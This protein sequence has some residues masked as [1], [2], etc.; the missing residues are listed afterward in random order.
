M[1]CFWRRGLSNK[2]HSTAGSSWTTRYFNCCQWRYIRFSFTFPSL[3]PSSH[4]SFVLW[5]WLR[6]VK[7]IFY[8]LSDILEC[9][10]HLKNVRSS[11]VVRGYC[12]K[13]TIVVTTMGALFEQQDEKILRRKVLVPSCKQRKRWSQTS[14]LGVSEHGRTALSENYLK[15]G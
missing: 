10:T 4:K 14:S 11:A 5:P 2:W 9:R 1:F 3:L 12:L 8:K 6:F 15:H 7:L 13:L